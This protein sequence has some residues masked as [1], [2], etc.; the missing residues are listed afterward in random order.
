MDAQKTATPVI[1]L[2]S[3]R[4]RLSHF[5]SDE[6]GEVKLQE[7]GGPTQSE[8]LPRPPEPEGLCDP[9][10]GPPLL[11]I[12]CTLYSSENVGDLVGFERCNF[13]IEVRKAVRKHFAVFDTLTPGQIK[14][15][16]KKEKLGD[17][18]RI[19]RTSGWYI[20]LKTE[21]SRVDHIGNVPKDYRYCD[22]VFLTCNF[23]RR[24]YITHSNH[25]SSSGHMI[26]HLD[27]LHVTAFQL[28]YT[29]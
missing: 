9:D 11:T 3:Q 13:S 25:T 19:R 21:G 24:A 8:E 12:K 23:L 7:P 18:L 15:Q 22:H 29:Q 2:V 1:G 10:E 4:E 20:Y 28:G 16:G 17:L 5:L 27:S 6:P 14:R 26:K